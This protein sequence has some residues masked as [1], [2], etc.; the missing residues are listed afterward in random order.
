MSW[1]GNSSFYGWLQ[2]IYDKYEKFKCLW[3]SCW[4][5]LRRLGTMCRNVYPFGIKRWKK[6]KEEFNFE[7]TTF[8]QDWH[9]GAVT[10][11]NDYG[12]QLDP[13]RRKPSNTSIQCQWNQIII[14]TL[15]MGTWNY[16]YGRW[17]LPH[18]DCSLLTKARAA[19]LAKTS[20]IWLCAFSSRLFGMPTRFSTTAT[21]SK[22]QTSSWWS[23]FSWYWWTICPS[24]WYWRL[25]N[26]L[27]PCGNFHV[28]SPEGFTLEGGWSGGSGRRST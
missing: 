3:G 18:P 19:G 20:I 15:K 9:G 6:L 5:N 7:E 8:L 2:H 24:P 27:Y 26:R 11:P 25:E 10:K 21:P 28:D 13:Q 14:W 4:N 12:W 22:S 23:P 17:N 16:E 1:Y